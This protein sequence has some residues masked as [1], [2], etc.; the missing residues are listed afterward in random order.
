MLKDFKLW[1]LFATCGL[2]SVGT[3]WVLADDGFSGGLHRKGTPAQQEEARTSAYA[4][5]M[6]WEWKLL[7]VESLEDDEEAIE[8]SAGAST[9]RDRTPVTGSGTH[10]DISVD[11]TVDDLEKLG[12]AAQ[13]GLDEA[14]GS[15]QEMLGVV[16]AST[17][18]NRQDG[19]ANEEEYSIPM[20]E[21][22]R[23]ATE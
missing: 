10:S 5:E 7:D 19:R 9:H 13:E 14:V 23:S 16:G 1:G 21:L 4:T 6:E 12:D 20:K 15:M 17:G 2:L 11:D 22:Q 18:I 8:T 3:S